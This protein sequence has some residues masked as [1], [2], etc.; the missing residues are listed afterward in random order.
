MSTD[1]FEDIGSV[2]GTFAKWDN[3]GDAYR[4]V[5]LAYSVDGGTDFNG[6][7]VPQIVLG[8]DEGNVVIN[9]SQKNLRNKLR[10]GAPKLRV[11]RICLVT[12]SGTYEAPK[13][14]GKE[15]TVQVRDAKPGEVEALAPAVGTQ[16][17]DEF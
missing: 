16:D 8:T 14:L 15:F 6:E 10:D 11:G 17:D 3:V 13:G 4:G 1:E 5:I 9:G 12:F 2:S 7:V